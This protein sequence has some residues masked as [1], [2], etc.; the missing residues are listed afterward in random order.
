[1]K[2]TCS[3][4]FTEDKDNQV[5]LSITLKYLIKKSNTWKGHGKEKKERIFEVKHNDGRT[6]MSCTKDKL[7]DFTLDTVLDM[8]KFP[9][10][11]EV[12]HINVGFRD[13]VV[14][15]EEEGDN[16]DVSL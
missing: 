10:N 14:S 7:V 16:D 8:M 5:L 13:V 2:I 6:F 9:S 12:M 11:G 4:S 15:D 1:M 3:C